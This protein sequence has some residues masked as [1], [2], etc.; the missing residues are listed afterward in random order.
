AVSVLRPGA[1]YAYW[2]NN[3]Q[4]SK[5]VFAEMLRGPLDLDWGTSGPGGTLPSNKY[6]LQI[7][8]WLR[9]PTTD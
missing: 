6:Y 4:R 2:Y 5:R 7:I 3:P 9:V 1:F 8:G